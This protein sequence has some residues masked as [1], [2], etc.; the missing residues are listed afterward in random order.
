M[1]TLITG[2]SGF[3][4]SHSEGASHSANLYGFF[5]A[6]M[7]TIHAHC[8]C[9]RRY[10]PCAGAISRLVQRVFRYGLFTICDNGLKTCDFVHISDVARTILAAL[11]A[12]STGTINVAT[13]RSVTLPELIQAFGL[14]LGR[15]IK[16]RQQ[17]ARE[18]D[19]EQSAATPARMRSEPGITDALL[20]PDGL[21]QLRDSL[22]GASV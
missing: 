22:R 13:G 20:W 8:G 17:P 5:A 14:A 6:G 16:V 18:G 4:D 2:R 12:A 3:I 15:T 7:R 11:T 10:S 1:F 19:I 9:Q 21:R